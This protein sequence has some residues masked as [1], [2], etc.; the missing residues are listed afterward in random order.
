MRDYIGL[1][2]FGVNTLRPVPIRVLINYSG[3]RIFNR[4]YAWYE[5]TQPRFSL[6][7]L[8]GFPAKALSEGKLCRNSPKGSLSSC[9]VSFVRRNREISTF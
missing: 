6:L 7:F 8:P 9:V 2:K 5:H 1:E 4:L 3:K